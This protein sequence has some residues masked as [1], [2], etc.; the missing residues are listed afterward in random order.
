MQGLC[1]QEGSG[2]F[3]RSPEYNTT[4]IVDHQPRSLTASEPD[5]PRSLY[6]DLQGAQNSGSYTDTLNFGIHASML[7][8]LEV[9]IYPLTKASSPL[10]MPL[11]GINMNDL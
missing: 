2:L 10:H 1:Q 11:K 7:G 6:L 3:C 4:C 5:L 8:M 9:Y